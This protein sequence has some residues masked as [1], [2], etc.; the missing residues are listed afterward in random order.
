[1]ALTQARQL[2]SKLFWTRS[3]KMHQCPQE[4]RLAHSCNTAPQSSVLTS[5]IS[6]LCLVV[7]EVGAN[8]RA[9]D[10]S[11]TKK[12]PIVI[13]NQHKQFTVFILL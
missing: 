11:T 8:E 6:S 7:D 9:K 2:F 3:E 1:M 12:M 13:R 4:F 5:S 10:I